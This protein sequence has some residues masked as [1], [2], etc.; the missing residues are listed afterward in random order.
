MAAMKTNPL[1]LFAAIFAVAIAACWSSPMAA[2][3]PA[4]GPDVDH[5][6]LIAENLSKLFS[7][8][9]KVRNIGVSELR[10]VP[11]PTG[12][13]WGSCVRVSA[14]SMAGQPTAPRT[15]IV[16]FLRGAI[17]ERRAPNGDEC[18]GAKFQPLSA[19]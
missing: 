8:D 2:Q 3:Q 4:P 14:T 11:S 5:R 16:I 12:L 13:V 15:Y 7:A 18:A 19:G 6:K 10:R 9:A 1:S 17:A